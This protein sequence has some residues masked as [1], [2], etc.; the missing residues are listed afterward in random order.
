MDSHTARSRIEMGGDERGEEMQSGR[1]HGLEFVVGAPEIGAAEVVDR[2]R[3]H[4][5]AL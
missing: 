1:V 4:A 5:L 2:Y 3:L